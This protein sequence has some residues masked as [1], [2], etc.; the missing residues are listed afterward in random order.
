MW[1]SA[2]AHLLQ[3]LLGRRCHK[4]LST[5]ELCDA[6]SGQSI[7]G[8]PG[9]LRAHTSDTFPRGCQEGSMIDP[10]LASHRLMLVLTTPSVASGALKLACVWRV[11]SGHSI[12]GRPLGRVW[13]APSL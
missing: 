6:E 5:G 12:G 3:E 8:L 7:C 9:G 4:F 13:A 1:P 11:C 2:V 10:I